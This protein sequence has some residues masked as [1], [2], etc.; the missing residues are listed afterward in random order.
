MAVPEA[1]DLVGSE[2]SPLDADIRQQLRIVL[3][4]AQPV[5]EDR[6]RYLGGWGYLRHRPLHGNDMFHVK[7]PSRLC[8]LAD[9]TELH[10][11]N[12]GPAQS[13]S[14]TTRREGSTPSL[15]LRTP[16]MAATAS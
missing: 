16:P 6:R 15:S 3:G 10:R 11:C 7:H 14:T 8:P 1:I 9:P 5:P 2:D 12:S 4:E 13:S